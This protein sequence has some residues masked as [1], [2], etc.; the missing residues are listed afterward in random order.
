MKRLLFLFIVISPLIAIA[1][2]DEISP[3]LFPK[4]EKGL[5]VL[6]DDPTR[7]PLLLNYAVIDERM[8]YMDI[9][10]AF[11]ELNTRKVALVN[12]AGR[13]FVPTKKKSFYERIL[14]GNEEYYITHRCRILSKGKYAGYGT[15]SQTAV[16]TGL[17]IPNS[18]GI[19]Y[20]LAPEELFEGIDET[21]ILV[22]NGNKY[23]KITSLKVLVNLFK[24]HQAKIEAYAKE[25][26]TNFKKANQIRA[27]L[28]YA[29]SL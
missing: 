25:N 29:F 2:D 23:V 10:S 16:I 11:H 13:I 26:K 21:I 9:D 18:S 6:K 19:S 3:F 20:M 28:E 8:I 17:I 15:Y 4:F 22:K 5:V 7:I 1:G 24:P 27:I 12:V 14:V